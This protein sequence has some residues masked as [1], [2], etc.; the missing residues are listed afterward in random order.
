MRFLVRP[1]WVTLTVG[2]VL[3]AIACFTLLAPWQFRR[4]EEKRTQNEAVRSSFGVEPAPID[5]VDQEWRQVVLTGTY[6]AEAEVVV[7]LR[8]VQGEPAF[9]VLTPLRLTGGDTVLVDRGFLRPAAGRSAQGRGNQVPEY[10]AAPGG[11]VT[12]VGRLRRDESGD[13][14]PVNDS[15]HLQVY[16]VNAATVATATGVALRPGYVQLNADQPGVLG[17]LPL[18]RLD[19]GPYLAYSLQWAG[20]GAMALI[21]LVLLARR[22][23]AE[24][25]AAGAPQPHQPREQG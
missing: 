24:L 15:G 6:L 22:E 19:A 17:P 7:R 18:P 25:A 9:E 13:R 23:R 8:T 2:V 20:F 1:G 3:F 10:A 5:Q 16:A 14:A 11:Q 21:G 4:H 12:V